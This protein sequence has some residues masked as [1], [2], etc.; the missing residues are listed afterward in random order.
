MKPELVRFS[1]HP[2]PFQ[3]ETVRCTNA[4]CECTE[5]AFRVRERV[6]RGQSAA[7]AVA[8]QV[9]MNGQT[10]EEVDPPPRPPEIARLVEEFLRDYPPAEREVIRRS[11]QEKFKLPGGCGS[12]AS[13]RN[14]LSMESWFPSA[15][16]ST[17]EAAEKPTAR[18]SSTGSST[19]ASGI[20]WTT[21]TVRAPNAIATKSICSSSAAYPPASPAAASLPRTIFWPSCPLTGRAEIVGCDRGTPSEAKAILATWQEQY[22]SDFKDLRWRYEKVKEIA[23]RSVPRQT[24]VS[25]QTGVSRRNDSL[26][27]APATVGGRIGRNAP[28]PC[29]SGKKFKKCCGQNK[30]R[31]R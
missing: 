16:S 26:P 2:H 4:E 25:G 20:S 6:K 30:D 12:I 13:T 1:S 14:A 18:P 7:G 19:R 17:T 9:R 3:V 23:R 27:K 24:G 22:G 5:V 29:G 11:T 10:W 21:Y 15:K 31:P 28:C 8:F